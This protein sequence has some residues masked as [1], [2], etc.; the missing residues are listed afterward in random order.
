MAAL[1]DSLVPDLVE[2]SEVKPGQLDALLGEEVEVWKRRFSWDFR[3]SADLLQRFLQ[4]RALSGYA[5]VS[6]DQ[7]IGYSYYVCEARKGVIGDLYLRSAYADPVRESAL[8]AAVVQKLMQTPGVRRIESQL[9]LLSQPQN[10]SMLPSLPHL[11]RHTRYFM[12]IGRD[13]ILKLTA[14]S[15]SYRVSF[16]NWTERYSE[17]MAYVVAGAYRGHVDSEINDQYRSIPGA[18]QFLANIIKF[19]GCGR[20]SPDAS[21]LAIDPGTGRLCGMCLAS[22]VSATTGHI[23]Q[24]CVLPAIRG[25]DLGYELLRQTLV[26]L[27]DSGG[28]SGSLT[29]TCANVDAIR[30]YE[31]VGFQVKASFPALVWDGF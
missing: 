1:S 16:V 13:A 10:Q 11:R 6:S 2:L 15:P 26:K 5:L 20:F 28:L 31:S 17:D 4:I 18:R 19:P 23:T 22:Y 7:V 27:A 29:V 12:E 25:L 21:V 14:R 8:L 30:L 3:P 24:L 9:M